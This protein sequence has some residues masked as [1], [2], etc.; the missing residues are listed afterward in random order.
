V[1][2]DVYPLARID[3]D[4]VAFAGR[5]VSVTKITDGL[6]ER[7]SMRKPR[8]GMT[9]P[10]ISEMLEG[11][12]YRFANTQG[13]NYLGGRPIFFETTLH[14]LNTPEF[15]GHLYNHWYNGKDKNDF[16]NAWGKEHKYTG[17]H[18]GMV[19]DYNACS[20]CGACLVACQAENNIPVVGKID[21]IKGREMHWIRIDRYYRGNEADPDHAFQMMLCQHCG[22]A[23]C[24]TV[25][26]VA[27]TL[28]NDEGLNTMIYNR[29]VGTRYCL[30]NCPYKVRR[31]NWHQYSEFRTG[32]HENQKRVSPLELA[33]NPDVTVRTRG[34]MEKCTFC[35]HR[36]KRAKE[37]SRTR[38]T[39]LLDGEMETACQTSCPGKAITFGDRNDPDS[40]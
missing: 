9:N 15:E 26:P 18:W 37:K 40:K 4:T 35:V 36:I 5:K 17:H 38:G 12:K 11:P 10:S 30:N 19:I 3:A 1:G 6:E 28:H 27:A 13:H 24:E 25:C 7:N 29:C 32:F 14:Q 23:P 20:A 16:I 33:L 31:F 21:I 34:V 22:T 39:A 8:L 2:V